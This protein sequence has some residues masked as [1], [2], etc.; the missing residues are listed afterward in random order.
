M[1]TKIL[2]PMMSEISGKATEGRV[3]VPL[4]LSILSKFGIKGLDRKI[5]DKA[6]M[7]VVK[8]ADLQQLFS[9]I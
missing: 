7:G 4:V 6:N 2:K 3:K 5:N 1:D 9:Q 8:V